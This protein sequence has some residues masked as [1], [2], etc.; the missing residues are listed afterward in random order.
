MMR[1]YSVILSVMLT[2]EH[3]ENGILVQR[4]K[5]FLYKLYVNFVKCEDS[6]I[7]NSCSAD[8]DTVVYSFHRFL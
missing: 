7:F 2:R 5:T 8:V 3:D 6:F 1:V 4:L